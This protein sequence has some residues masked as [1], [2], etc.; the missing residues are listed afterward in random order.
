MKYKYW[1]TTNKLGIKFHKTVE[2]ALIIYKEAGNDYW[3]KA[4]NKDMSK[5]KV[6]WQRVDGITPDQARSR[7]VKE[8]IGH[9]E[10]NCHII[11]DAH[12]EFQQNARFMA[13]V[14]MEEAPNSIIYSSVVSR[15]S[16]CIIF[17]LASLHGVEITAIDLKNPT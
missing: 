8:M 6:A 10:I 7:S 15:D 11:F 2:E 5:V 4:L 12:M 9:Q 3:E 16:I 1:S 13:R 17:L 14:H